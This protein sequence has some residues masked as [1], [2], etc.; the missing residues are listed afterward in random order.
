MA[1]KKLLVAITTKRVLGRRVISSGDKVVIV[2][3]KVG[4]NDLLDL[5]YPV[6]K[7]QG[8]RPVEGDHVH[9]EE[10]AEHR[11]VVPKPP[12]RLSEEE[13]Q[14]WEAQYREVEGYL[15]KAKH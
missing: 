11:L 3:V 10:Y 2:E 7:L 14:R 4:E 8:A 13:I 5:W 1:R 6:N 9:V 15:K 12:R